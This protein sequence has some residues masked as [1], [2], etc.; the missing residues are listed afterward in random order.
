[1]FGV[2]TIMTTMKTLVSTVITGKA[3]DVSAD[4][5]V[6]YVSPPQTWLDHIFSVINRVIRPGIALLVIWMFWWFSTEPEKAKA[7]MGVVKDMPDQMWN[8]IYMLLLSIGVTKA[9][10]DA[11]TP[12]GSTIVVKQ[13]IDKAQTEVIEGKKE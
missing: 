12:G 10:R 6:Q 3:L 9:I 7:W 13:D 1:M 4:A 8:I 11:K 2:N 5:N